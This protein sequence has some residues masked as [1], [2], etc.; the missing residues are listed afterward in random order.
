M[1]AAGLITMKEARAQQQA[2][3]KAAFDTKSVEDTIKALGGSATARAA[4]S[5]SPRPTSPRTAPSCRWP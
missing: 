3:N 5:R 1:A 4:T 2:W